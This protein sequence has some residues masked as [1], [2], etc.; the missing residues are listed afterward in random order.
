V[1]TVVLLKSLSAESFAF[2]SKYLAEAQMQNSSARKTVTQNSETALFQ[3]P[4]R[5]SI[6]LALQK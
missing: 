1:Q 4:E 5:V 3:Q 6:A 2:A